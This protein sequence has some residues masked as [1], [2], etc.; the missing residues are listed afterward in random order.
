MPSVAL[1]PPPKPRAGAKS[2]TASPHTP[3]LDRLRRA[4]A[5]VSADALLVT[6]ATDVGYLPGFLGGDSYLLVP[7]SGRPVIISD[8]RYQEEL[9]VV[10]TIAEVLIRAKGL[11]AAAADA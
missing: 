2:K 11:T 4:I 7:A 1:K 5:G 6:N 10:R 9:N 3:R 8:F